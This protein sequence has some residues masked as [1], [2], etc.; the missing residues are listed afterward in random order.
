MAQRLAKIMIVDQQEVLR[1]GVRETLGAHHE[2]EVAGE[3]MDGEET[4]ALARDLHPDLIVL[5]HCLKFVNGLDLTRRLKNELPATRVILY[6]SCFT[7][8]LMIEYI[9][10]GARGIVLKTD[11]LEELR[12]A[13]RKVLAGKSYFSSAIS[14]I[15]VNKL[16]LTDDNTPS[17]LTPRE[18]Q[19][20]QLISEGQMNKQ[21]AYILGLSTKTIET[22]RASA[23]SKL[24]F[25]TTAQLVRYAVRNNLVSV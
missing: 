13:A 3:A 12:V 10:A 20:V 1:L 4:L 24:N 14:E 11:N 9:R 8:D 19:V 25:M 15:L 17:A 5:E 6:T 7:D 22:H 21:I 16:S 2:W 23:M 18:R